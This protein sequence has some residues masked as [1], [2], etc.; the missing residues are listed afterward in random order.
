MVWCESSTFSLEG[1]G[2][3]KSKCDVNLDLIFFVLIENFQLNRLFEIFWLPTPYYI[4]F[5]TYCAI[6]SDT[7]WK[8]EKIY[9]IADRGK[10]H[11][12]IR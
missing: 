4:N 12:K 9:T 11:V 3:L 2:T 10:F 8:H 1:E 7:V 5:H 6:V